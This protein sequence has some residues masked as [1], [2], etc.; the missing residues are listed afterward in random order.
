M[1]AI[2]AAAS[3]EPRDFV[4]ESNFG[5]GWYPTTPGQTANGALQYDAASPDKYLRVT[6]T[7][8]GDIVSNIYVD[9]L[10]STG[11]PLPVF[12][13]LPGSNPSR[14]TLAS[15]GGTEVV[16]GVTYNVFRTSYSGV[17]PGGA[18]FTDIPVDFYFRQTSPYYAGQTAQTRRF[19]TVNSTPVTVVRNPANI[20]NTNVALADAPAP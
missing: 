8:A 19:V 14:S 13:A 2:Y 11:W 3:V 16:N 20:V 9:V 5:I 1:V 7:Q 15:T 6:G 12:T 18:P 17:V 10:I 4:L